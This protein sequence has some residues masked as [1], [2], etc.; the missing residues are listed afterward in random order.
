ME[1]GCRGIVT[2]SADWYSGYTKFSDKTTSSMSYRYKPPEN[3]LPARFES[4]TRE[5]LDHLYTL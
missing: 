4:L 2:I 3:Y 5:L 1:W